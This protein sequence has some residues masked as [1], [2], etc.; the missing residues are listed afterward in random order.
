MGQPPTFMYTLFACRR[1][2][3]YTN[4][5]LLRAKLL[6][7]SPCIHNPSGRPLP[8]FHAY[9]HKTNRELS[10]LHSNSY[11]FYTPLTV[12]HP[13]FSYL[14]LISSMMQ[15]STTPR[16]RACMPYST[17]NPECSRETTHGW[18][19]DN[20]CF[21][22][23]LPGKKQAYGNAWLICLSAKLTMQARDHHRYR[24]HSNY[25]RH[26]MILSPYRHLMILSPYR[27]PMSA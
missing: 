27:Y 21:W 15:G 3:T 10:N 6:P 24:R 9:Q 16:S 8:S 4:R 2:H 19:Y 17:H 13:A 1:R 26:P 12:Q 7:L 23:S 18:I 5:K 20:A 14:Q 11:M 25:C 22:P